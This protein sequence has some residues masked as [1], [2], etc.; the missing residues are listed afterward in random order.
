MDTIRHIVELM[1]ALNWQAVVIVL[2]A[3]GLI[4]YTVHRVTSRS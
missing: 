4:G 3:L 2:A 1:N